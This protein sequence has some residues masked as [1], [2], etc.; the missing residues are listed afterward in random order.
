VNRGDKAF[1]MVAFVHKLCPVIPLHKRPQKDMGNDDAQRGWGAAMAGDSGV[2]CPH[3]IA[4]TP[5]YPPGT[6]CMPTPEIADVSPHAQGRLAP[7]VF[8]GR[9]M[10]WPRLPV[11]AYSRDSIST[12]VPADARTWGTGA[13][14]RD[15]SRGRR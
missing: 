3:P 15:H 6:T 8:Q 14:T 9:L 13:S 11:G 5:S 1:R 2:H 4:S 10:A 7:P 12:R